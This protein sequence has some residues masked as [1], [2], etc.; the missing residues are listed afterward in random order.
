MSLLGQYGSSINEPLAKTLVHDD[1]TRLF[2]IVILFLVS[3][4]ILFKILRGY[5]EW[6]QFRLF[7]PLW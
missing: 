4:A 6:I 7:I 5:S 2:I 1:I 3:G